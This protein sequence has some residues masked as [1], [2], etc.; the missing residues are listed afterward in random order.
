MNYRESYLGLYRVQTDVI[1]ALEDIV[2]RM[3]VAHLAMAELVIGAESG[4]KLP[5]E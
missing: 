5:E 3:K 1:E 2:T 4:A